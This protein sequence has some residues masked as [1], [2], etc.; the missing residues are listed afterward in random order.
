M[1][2]VG[3]Y[4]DFYATAYAPFHVERQVV[5]S[6]PVGLIL[7]QQGSH[8]T[9]SETEDAFFVGVALRNAVTHSRMDMGDGA[10]PV[11]N[12]PGIVICQPARSSARFEVEGDHTV[13]G[14]VAAQADLCRLIG[15]DPARADAALAR[16]G[17]RQIPDPD[18][19]GALRAMWVHAA[20]EGLSGTLMIDGLLRQV[21][22]R[23]LVH[24]ERGETALRRLTLSPAEMRRVRERIE[25]ALHGPITTAMLAAETGVPTFHF[26]H[27]FEA[28]MGVASAA[29]VTQCRLERAKRML[30]EGDAPLDWIATACGFVSSAH[31]AARMSVQEATT[32]TAYRAAARI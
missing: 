9:T 2:G 1:S 11:I 7:S 22:A 16:L 26:D 13:V 29:F 20:T 24:A 23:L 14:M 5:G 12:R 18:I 15:G 19:T 8:E 10:R 6:L 3:A 25:A 32:P 31:M 17:G 4:L 30:V 27:A 21:V 28:A